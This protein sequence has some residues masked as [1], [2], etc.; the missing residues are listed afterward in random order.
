MPLEFTRV[1]HKNPCPICNHKDY[2]EIGDRAILCQRIESEKPNGRPAGG[3]FHFF[4][5][6]APVMSPSARKTRY[7]EPLKEPEKLLKQLTGKNSEKSVCAL[8][9]ELKVEFN[10][11][12]ELGC[13]ALEG[14][15]E[16][17][18]LN[19]AFPMLD[20]A[21]KI[22]GIRTRDWAGNKKAI[23]G[24]RAGLFFSE[25][26]E[27]LEL[28]DNYPVAFICEGPTDTAAALD[29]GFYG[30]GR[31]NCATGNEFVIN[32]LKRL[33]IRKV[34]IAANNDELKTGGKRPGLDGA[35]QIKKQI[36]IDSSI[37][38]PPSPLKDLRQFHQSGGTREM[39]LNDLKTK[40]FSL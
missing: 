16:N 1:S 39:I 11:L 6:K 27:A 25:S 15:S 30:I 28:L 14:W 20:D 19:F 3:W 12:M 40:I 34:V 9:R 2:C 36:P 17:N 18:Y 32:L 26:P 8:A 23:T 5:D 31:P 24:S 13:V 22:I 37:W 21:G 38:L 35:L 7:T 29:L 33:G 4:G 10:S